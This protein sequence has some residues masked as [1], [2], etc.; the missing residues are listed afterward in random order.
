M[1]I[2]GKTVNP[3]TGRNNLIDPQ[4]SIA[5]KD[6]GTIPTVQINGTGVPKN[7][8]PNQQITPIVYDPDV[9]N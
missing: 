1:R 4:Q 5:P 7:I 6:G 8:M 3:A 2:N 9:F